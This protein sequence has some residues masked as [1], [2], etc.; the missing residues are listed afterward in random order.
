MTGI[1]S[2]ATLAAYY[3]SAAYL[4]GKKWGG[5]RGALFGFAI[6]FVLPIIGWLYLL[7]SYGLPNAA[8][9]TQ[10]NPWSDA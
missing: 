8:H 5:A 7:V 6:A 2:V 10:N 9:S 1:L 4:G 3:A